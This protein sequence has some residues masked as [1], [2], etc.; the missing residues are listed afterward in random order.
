[1]LHP[2]VQCYKLFCFLVRNTKVPNRYPH[3]ISHPGCP[4]FEEESPPSG[5]MLLPFSLPSR[6]RLVC[7]S[8]CV[9]QPPVF[10]DPVLK[11]FLHRWSQGFLQYRVRVPQATNLGE[12]LKTSLD[13]MQV[14]S[15]SR[16]C[17]PRE[18][19]SDPRETIE[20]SPARQLHPRGT[21]QFLEPGSPAIL[22]LCTSSGQGCGM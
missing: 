11:S 5:L 4:S 18:T 7:L 21:W 12:N 13:I 3:P 17:A 22:A 20:G 16:Q 2:L 9:T 1:M 8:T 10:F 6:V 19:S 14:D 15:F